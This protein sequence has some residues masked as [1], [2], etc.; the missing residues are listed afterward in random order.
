MTV[1]QTTLPLVLQSHDK[2]YLDADNN[3]ICGTRQQSRLT[4]KCVYTI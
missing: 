4:L 1:L 2:T 3:R